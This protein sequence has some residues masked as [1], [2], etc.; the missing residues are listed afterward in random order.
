MTDFS[1]LYIDGQWI[2][3]QGQGLADVINPANGEV[4]GRVPLGNADDVDAAAQAAK[5]AFASWSQTSAAERSQYLA[6]IA[7]GLEKNL[8]E[9][10]A[11][12]SSELGSPMELSLQVQAG[13]PVVVCRSYIELT[14]EME[15][16]EQVGNSLVLREPV[17]VCGFITPWNYPLHQIVAKVAP[18]LAAGC[19]VVLK[20]SQETPLNAFLFAKIIHE[21]GLP[22][23]VFNLVSGPGKI[24]G[25]AIAAHPAI[26]M[27]SITGSTRAGIRVAELA[28]KSVKRVCQELGG[29]S[30]SIVLEGANLEAA[31]TEGVGNIVFN[32]GQ[33]CSALT[34]LIVPA[35]QQEAAIAISQAV[36]A[37]IPQGDPSRSDVA[38]GPL[39]SEGQ[40][41]TVVRYIRIG[42]EE[43]AR[44]VAGGEEKP[45]GLEKGAYV[46]PTIFADVKN[47]MRIAQEEIFGPVLCIIPYETEAEAIAI[48]NDSPYGL[49]GAVWAADT[50]KAKAVARRIRTGQLSLNGGAFNPLAPFGGYKQSGNGRELGAH[51]LHDFIEL[52]ALQLTV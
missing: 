43:G 45:A 15:K 30:A 6:K 2:K 16:E 14:V 52:K 46:R 51:A 44:L 19:T 48:A 9:M 26:D 28:A 17:G 42:I 50:A 8:P 18:A 39:V 4:A 27:V 38:M 37:T 1:Q 33:T 20:P 25:E 31:V 22:A 49:A 10:A 24:V 3:P 41:E 32:S 21:A 47:S 35:A 40:R 12:I 36:L 13:L 23:G 5:R 7:D 34:R 29:K 11:L